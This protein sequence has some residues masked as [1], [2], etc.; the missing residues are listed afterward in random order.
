MAKLTTGKGRVFRPTVVRT[1]KGRKVKTQTRFYWAEYRDADSIVRRHALKLPNGAGVADQS[2]AMELLRSILKLEERRGAG[3]I[4]P[5]VEAAGMAVR[6]L[7][8]QLLRHLRQKQ[9]GRSYIRQVAAYAKVIFAKGDI[10]TLAQFR[11]DRIVRALGALHGRSPKTVKEY[12]RAV[13]L[14]GE[15]AVKI[16]RVASRNPVDAIPLPEVRG[17]VRKVRRALTV[18]EAVALLRVAPEGRRLF[19]AAAILT[20]LRMGELGQLRWSDVRGIEG[21][22]PAIVLR[23]ATTKAKRADELPLHPD[24]AEALRYARGPF[25]KPTDRIFTTTPRLKTFKADLVRAGL[26]AVG[27]DGARVETADD[28]GTTLDRHALRTAFVSWLGAAGVDPRNQVRLARHAAQGL[29]QR[30]YQD[31]RLLPD[32]WAEVAKLPAII[33]MA[34]EAEAVE[35]LATGTDGKV[36]VGVVVGGGRNSSVSRSKAHSIS[37]TMRNRA[38]AGNGPFSEE[39]SGFSEDSEIPM[40]GLEP[41]ASWSTARRSNQLSYIGTQRRQAQGQPVADN[42]SSKREAVHP[43]GGGG[44]DPSGPRDACGRHAPERPTRLSPACG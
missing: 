24:L 30:N 6:V 36:V 13:H 12:R 9:R 14:L 3:L 21:D 31:V 40:L 10:E 25:A 28:I 32:L 1:R 16:A 15:H 27:A 19:Y 33:R 8:A 44:H 37:G 22:R 20:G 39:I 43:V 35:A 4:D 41:R 17:D 29:T 42:L 5:E 38:V 7:L 34:T 23:A 2:V 18:D 26:A 11:E